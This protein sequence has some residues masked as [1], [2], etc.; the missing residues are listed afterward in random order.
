MAFRSGTQA[1]KNGAAAS[2]S[3]H[4]FVAEVEGCLTREQVRRRPSSRAGR[5]KMAAAGSTLPEM[6][7]T[8]SWRRRGGGGWNL[9]LRT[10]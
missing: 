5:G 3:P 4:G 1:A 6:V 8:P 9:S 10:R 2:V 7:Q